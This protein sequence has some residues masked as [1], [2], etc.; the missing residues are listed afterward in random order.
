MKIEGSGTSSS[1]P[2]LIC[3]HSYSFRIHSNLQV[4]TCSTNDI[5]SDCLPRNPILLKH[6][7]SARVD[8]LIG[9]NWDES[10]LK[11]YREARQVLPLPITPLKCIERTFLGAIPIE[12][13]N[14]AGNTMDARYQLALCA[15]AM[16]HLRQLWAGS[17][18]KQFNP[19]RPPIVISLS[20]IGHFWCYYIMY[21]GPPRKVAGGQQGAMN[22]QTSQDYH[23]VY[24]TP[25]I[26]LGPF[27]AGNTVTLHSTLYLFQFFEVLRSWL[28]EEWAPEIF[29]ELAGIPIAE[30]SLSSRESGSSALPSSAHGSAHQT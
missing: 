11:E 3:E 1:S 7:Q 12:V 10:P 30:P 15:S 5:I 13:K 2:T 26:F 23:G 14:A 9:Y 25:R 28:V 29:E 16:L 4:V 22:A 24:S 21:L 18:E 27:V 8:L 6:I 17:Q 19:D 20:V